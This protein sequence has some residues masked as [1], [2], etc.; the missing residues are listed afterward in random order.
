MNPQVKHLYAKCDLEMDNLICSLKDFNQNFESSD[1]NPNIPHL[2]HKEDKNE[3]YRQYIST[4]QRF[5]IPRFV[6]DLITLGFFS[7]YI[8]N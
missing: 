4:L 2:V 3:S 5:T 1:L 7:K 6:V 8:Y